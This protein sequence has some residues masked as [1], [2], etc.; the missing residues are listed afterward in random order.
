MGPNHHQ[1]SGHVGSE[2]WWCTCLLKAPGFETLPLQP[3]LVTP[4]TNTFDISF[5]VLC[6]LP[7]PFTGESDWPTST[8]AH[9]K[10]DENCCYECRFAVGT[11]KAALTC[12]SLNFDRFSGRRKMTQQSRSTESTGIQSSFHSTPCRAFKLTQNRHY[13]HGSD[14]SRTIKRKL[15]A[16][17]LQFK[18]D[19]TVRRTNHSVVLWGNFDILVA[20]TCT[21]VV[22]MILRE[23]RFIPQEII[24]N[25]K[26]AANQ[27]KMKVFG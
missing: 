20:C 16:D 25:I 23:T 9:S 4:L 21:V 2:N 19:V 24:I 8:T 7:V 5:D 22:N 14:C 13:F 17:A 15:I 11:A 3:S 18:H 26:D 1:F 10:V 27:L 6:M 12:I